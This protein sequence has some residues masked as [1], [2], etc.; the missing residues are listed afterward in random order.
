VN[1]N[2]ARL[3]LRRD[4]EKTVNV[5]ELARPSDTAT[6]AAGS[7]LFLQRAVTNVFAELLRS[8]NLASVVL[9]KLDVTNGSLSWDDLANSRP[10][11][12]MLHDMTASAREISNLPGSNQTATLALRWN[13]NGTVRVEASGHIGPLGSDLNVSV[14]GFELRP[15]DPYLEPFLDLY[16]TDGRL[17]L[18]AKARLRASGE[19]LPE[20][21]VQG[22]ARLDDFSTVDSQANED[23]LKWKSLQVS[24]IDATLAPPALTIKEVSLLDLVARVAVRTNRL[25]NVLAALKVGVTN[26]ATPAETPTAD[27]PLGKGGLGQ[28]L[29]R[30]LR[31]ALASNT[32]AAGQLALPRVAVNTISLSNAQAQFSDRSVQPELRVSMQELNGTIS[33]I[34][35]EELK[36]A[37]VHFTG[38]A[39]RTGTFEINGKINP[40]NQQA[41]TEVQVTFRE[42]DLSPTSPYAGK[43]LG[44]R[45]SRGKLDLQINCEISQRHIKSTNEIVLDQLT[46]GEKVNSPDATSLPVRLGVALLKDRNGRIELEVPIDGS[47]DDP[48]FHFGKA[49]VGVLSSLITK[50]VTSPFAALGALFGSDGEEVSYQD[51]AP[52]SSELSAANLNKLKSLIDG[53]Y[54]RPALQLEIEGGFDPVADRDGLRQQK[55]E[56]ELRRQKWES[57]TRSEQARIAPEQVTLSP[58]ERAERLRSA[59]AKALQSSL[60]AGTSE[61]DAQS[62]PSGGKATKAGLTATASGSQK[63]A[64]ALLGQSD[65]PTPD[66]LESMKRSLTAAT[67][68]TDEELK[69]LATKRAKAVQQKIL[70]S[71]RIEASRLILSDQ[72][73][74]P[75][76]NNSSRVYFRLQ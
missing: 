43:Y 22:D 16:L 61:S 23:L 1:V 75:S 67:P 42:V 21:G 45:L 39:I 64:T 26:S 76:T 57:L 27:A 46:L 65:L 50:L 31:Q 2:G 14:Q 6:N 11:H 68:V 69:D 3:A 37:D 29:G 30:V 33:G 17:D 4:K 36:R 74:A 51:F 10:V 7:V 12:V 71:G 44:Y 15:L 66:E 13:T 41:P 35:S 59:Y 54:E 34:S 72:S 9:H 73:S 56:L 25:I 60:G 8:T 19:G 62:K 49:I 52:G 20:I 5:L 47:L 24:G 58:S 38:K 40:L 28:K 18:Q 63:G 48:Q 55:L 70:D 53:L 32:N